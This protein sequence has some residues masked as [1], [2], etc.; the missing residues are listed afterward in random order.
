VEDEIGLHLVQTRRSNARA[1]VPSYVTETQR[2]IIDPHTIT[3]NTPTLSVLESGAV[4]LRKEGKSWG[5]LFAHGGTQELSPQE[6]FASSYDT[7]FRTP[8]AAAMDDDVR[9]EKV[10]RRT[11]ALRRDR[12]QVCVCM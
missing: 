8:C 5:V 2:Q 9:K 10:L 7:H 11:Q 3:I 4:A 1:H 6:R 12:R